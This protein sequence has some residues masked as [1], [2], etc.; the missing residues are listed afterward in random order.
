MKYEDAT[1]MEWYWQVENWTAWRK[2]WASATRNRCF[3]KHFSFPGV[4]LA[5]LQAKISEVRFKVFSFQAGSRQQ[6][7]L[8]LQ[9]HERL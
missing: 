1:L 3:S 9:S 8:W 2:S 5:S 6:I 4:S 7:C